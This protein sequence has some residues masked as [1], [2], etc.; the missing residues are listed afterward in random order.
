MALL[1]S[2]NSPKVVVKSSSLNKEMILKGDFVISSKVGVIPKRIMRRINK[3]YFRTNYYNFANPEEGMNYGCVRDA[4]LPNQ[5]IFEGGNANDSIYYYLY[6]VYSSARYGNRCLIVRNATD[7]IF[8]WDFSTAPEV[9][10]LVKLRE[11]LRKNA[12]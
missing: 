12:P 2:C 6:E 11:F 3:G 1:V 7:S 5:R 4:N 10:S 9:K 8:Y